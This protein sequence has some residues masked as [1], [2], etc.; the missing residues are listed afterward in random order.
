PA[1]GTPPSLVLPPAKRA[2]LSNGLEIVVVE[3]HEAPLVDLTLISD[4]CFAAD[5][6]AK[7]GTARLATLMLQEGTKTRSSLQIAERAES[8][9]ATIG[10]GSSLDRSYL[11]M[12]ALSSRLGDS[13]ELY[14]DLILNPTFPATELE[15]LRGQTLASIQ[16]E[17]AQPG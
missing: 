13:L 10:V 11:G 15:R 5:S 6:L 2:K 3:R 14:T 7:P 4:A 12:N 17:K 16:Q 9:G 1:T 8:I